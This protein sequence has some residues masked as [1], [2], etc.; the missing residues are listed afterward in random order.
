MK[1]A[2]TNPQQVEYEKTVLE[3]LTKR[4]YSPDIWDRIGLTAGY[5]DQTFVEMGKL[6]AK[7]QAKQI[8][9]NDLVAIRN[10]LNS[11]VGVIR[12]IDAG[13]FLNSPIPA[14]FRAVL[15]KLVSAGIG[16]EEEI[17]RI[18]LMLP[19]QPSS[20]QMLER[21]GR[22]FKFIGQ[23]A[24]VFQVGEVIF[25][26]R[27]SDWLNN[28]IP[29]FKVGEKLTGVLVGMVGGEVSAILAGAA[30]GLAF[31]PVGALV[32][33]ILGAVAG[34][35]IGGK[36]GE[37]LWAPFHY[38]YTQ[39]LLPTVFAAP[40]NVE[41]ALIGQLDVFARN[42]GKLDGTWLVG[43]NL[44]NEQKVAL[45]ML[46]WQ[47][48]G[49]QQT[50]QLLAD[51]KAIFSAGFGAE[52]LMARDA[53]LTLIL[54]TAQ[55]TNGYS[56]SR[57]SVE[58]D[59]I[60]F[61]LP[62]GEPKVLDAFR[63]LVGETLDATDHAGW[64]TTGGSRV[65]F[66]LQQSALLGTVGND[67]LWGSSG[68][69]L[70]EGG[71]G[72]DELV[73]GA[74]A[75]E[76]NGGVGTDVLFGQAGD[77]R[78][79]GGD[80]SDY[81]YGGEGNDTYV[82]SGDYGS[83]WIVDSDGQGSLV[84][85]GTTLSG[86]KK[87]GE[88]AYFDAA[89]GWSYT[90]VGGDL[91]LNK[92]GSRSSIRIRD[93]TDG[94]L[95][96]VLDDQEAPQQD[97]NAFVGDFRKKLT[98]DGKYVVDGTDNYV[99]DGGDEPG[100]ND[101]FHGSDVA[102]RF[103]GLGGNDA[104]VARAGNDYIDGGDGDDVLFGGRGA[105]TILGGAGADF[106][107][108]S[109]EG[110]LL[111]PTDPDYVS[112]EE[113]LY[114]N[115]VTRGL[116][117]FAARTEE[118]EYG[119]WE[120]DLVDAYRWHETEDEGNT[121]SAGDGDDWVLAGLAND[122]VDGGSGND[123]VWGAGGSDYVSGG[124]G[125]DVLYGDG[126]VDREWRLPYTPADMQ[127]VD[128]LDGGEGD[129]VLF[130]QGAGDALF[131]GSGA[132]LIFGDD[133]DL[134]RSPAETAG[135]DYIEAGTG[136][137]TV[138]GGARSDRIDG[139]EGDDELWGD[140]GNQGT[141]PVPSAL[142]G[143]DYLDGGDGDDIA[144]GEGGHDVL[145]GGEGDDTLYGD[146]VQEKVA[147][148]HQ[149]TDYLDG[150][151]G[152]DLLVGGGRDDTLYGGTGD[153]TL[154]GDWTGDGLSVEGH[155]SDYLDG[156]DGHDVLIG[157]G[158]DDTLYGGSGDDRLMGDGQGDDD[159]PAA[160]QGRDVLDGEDGADFLD[161]GGGDDTLNGGV[162]SD[163]DTLI[164]GASNDELRGGDGDDLLRGDGAY[165]DVAPGDHGMDMISGGAGDD[166]LLG[167]GGLDDLN[168]GDGNDLIL[169][170]SDDL[171]SAAHGNDMLEGGAGGDTLV[172]HGGSDLLS[173]G[174]GRDFLIGDAGSADADG[175]AYGD[176]LLDGGVGDDVLIGNGGADQ[177]LG[178]EGDDLLYGGNGDDLLFGGSGRDVLYGGAGNDTIHVDG[179]DLIDGGEGDDIYE[180]AAGVNLQNV[181]QNS[182][183][184]DASGKSVI[185]LAGLA[186]DAPAPEIF[187]QNGSVQVWLNSTT[188]VALGSL[189]DVGNTYVD[190]GDG[191][192]HSLAELAGNPDGRISAGYLDAQTGQVVRSNTVAQDQFL[193]GAQS[194]DLLE[195]NEGD[196]WLDGGAG[197]DLLRGGAGKDAF[198]GGAGADLI[199]GGTGSDVLNGNLE[200]SSDDG[201]A[202]IYH[203]VV[204]DGI[205]W[206]VATGVSG[207]ARDVIE[208]GAGITR[209][210][211]QVE[212]LRANTTMGGVHMAITYGAGDRIV[213]EPGAEGTIKEIR[214]A[215]G[216]IVPMS[217]LVAS[218][219]EQNPN[220]RGN[221]LGTQADDRLIGTTVKD[222]IYGLGGNDRLEGRLGDDV[223][224]G[225]IGSN[226]YVFGTEDGNDQIV[227]TAGEFGTLRFSGA[228]QISAMEGDVLIRYGED[229]SVRIRGLL[230]RAGE[231]QRWTVQAPGTDPVNLVTLL[232]ASPGTDPG[233]DELAERRAQ[234][235]RQLNGDLMTLGQSSSWNGVSPAPTVLPESSITVEEG[236][237]LSLG[238]SIT[239]TQTTQTVTRT[240]SVAIYEEVVPKFTGTG[241]FMTLQEVT[242]KYGGIVPE[243]ATPVY[244]ADV[245]TGGAGSG[246]GTHLTGYMFSAPAASQYRIVGYETV[247]STTMVY[248]QVDDASVANVR[249][250]AA[251][252]QII[253]GEG[254]DPR[255][256]AVFRGT[257][258]TGAGDD[259]V[260]LN[261]VVMMPGGSYVNGQ[262]DYGQT[263]A[264]AP[265]R[266][267]NFVRGAGAW[268]DLGSGDDI[269][270]G[271]EANDV[272]VGGDGN[273][274]MDGQAGADTYLVSASGSGFDHIADSAEYD[275]IN[276]S[277]PGFGAG[278]GEMPLANMDTVEFDASVQRSALSYFWGATN[279][280][281][282]L[283]QLNIMVGGRLF[284]QIDY[285]EFVKQGLKAPQ[286][287]PALEQSYIDAGFRFW[288]E[289]EASAVGVERFRF[290]DGSELS[291]QDFL[292]SVPQGQP[293]ES[294][295]TWAGTNGDDRLVGGDG[296]DLLDG[297][298]GSDILIG[299]SGAD[300]MTGGLGH[301]EYEV[302]DVGDVIIEAAGS[303]YDVVNSA[304]DYTL[305]ENVEDLQ[306][307]GAATRGTGNDLDNYL[308]GNALDNLLEGQ[309]G[310][311]YLQGRAG[312][313]TLLGGA[314]DDDIEG[315]EGND[316]MDGGSG[317]DSMADDAL[318]DDTYRWGSGAGDDYVSDSGGTDNVALSADLT[319]DQ[320]QFNRV[321][322][323]LE[324]T[325]VGANDRLTVDGWFQDPANE[326]ESFRLSDGSEISNTQINAL[327][328]AM[329][330]FSSQESSS[331][332]LQADRVFLQPVLVANAL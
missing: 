58:D 304:V 171:E 154:V 314:G 99:R 258:E 265:G 311:D 103:L 261:S 81:L 96:I 13:K 118:G 102:E 59:V 195:T 33:G 43:T 321:D 225:G 327:I 239:T 223:L 183:I 7:F 34:G 178:G 37:S 177:L 306:L 135:D 187:V 205:D 52:T 164:G 167:D 294:A 146:D 323:D 299:G 36:A 210:D 91:I 133:K 127:G 161:G 208:F 303:G 100:A 307:K 17:R 301:D 300:T 108:G 250:T 144:F 104:V 318:S 186:P 244:A 23:A 212:N 10:V 232:N 331:E 140:S 233:S 60:Y 71:G 290:A 16:M 228:V 249:G 238:S 147:L 184:N 121:I 70:L 47:A 53:V 57:V 64:A 42:V 163:S 63:E 185:R 188:R 284:L 220:E 305:S 6:A 242:A 61:G 329:A 219:L 50:P 269:A 153:D 105:D 292:S 26:E 166:T 257:I 268:I 274:W 128:V 252:D 82:F 27:G 75:D 330:S 159:V 120:V 206:I 74:S 322:N 302:D 202:D 191:V 67:L 138:I 204:G 260:T 11:F 320:L 106:I 310:D 51:V 309:Q 315:G 80:N 190:L 224:S 158:L 110:K 200:D 293:S 287:P 298:G 30:G 134:D 216:T 86:G 73:A 15:S 126:E 87:R 267:N 28:G 18:N 213:L 192:E 66:A 214:L 266:S 25:E 198:V 5:W 150:E 152:K 278:Y 136:A 76:L 65:A 170:D 256:A 246:Y 282:G 56:V 286:L 196:D 235:V 236:V 72:D 48:V 264:D 46:M 68:E 143:D 111:P 211:L 296:G 273:D 324:V 2:D 95:G 168:G 131:G 122:V 155:G 132:D 90:K 288:L 237:E 243:G 276:D 125:R 270:F 281:T 148:A 55:L 221:V 149:G 328:Q 194:D 326:I 12:S 115:I 259:A 84:F 230:N 85:E 248:G 119:V 255:F 39:E 193:T 226:E 62:A 45:T 197:N 38:W 142:H 308:S 157:G 176:D 77:D 19:G 139:G 141:V 234:F 14:E 78:L 169:G 93:W 209:A 207:E 113:V 41:D 247:T 245:P 295:G 332:P 241:T 162:G 215:D 283:A 31:G 203:F 179:D 88:N 275:P 151:S 289:R 79:D 4:L 316:V 69:D 218:V 112:D 123:F 109:V 280:G 117:W 97:L 145:F 29:S 319:Q 3:D 182:I 297:R 107:Y 21:L 253:A 240:E 40:S 174:E 44:D 8:D 227:M 325:L 20:Q 160:Y 130:G 254:A 9:S 277:N 83:D 32:G 313:D 199:T 272:I 35:Y 22:S 217:E 24:G 229:S 1:L 285:S 189:Q 124:E 54:R 291:V 101:I 165:G 251:D 172:G 156:E 114:S 173:G 271:T 279:S 137:D 222:V 94:D 262:I 181:L 263:G 98:E 49:V 92:E 175:S 317:S 116:G 231:A 129:D 201:A 180:I 312:N 89:T